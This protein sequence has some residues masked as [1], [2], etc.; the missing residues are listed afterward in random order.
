M[1]KTVHLAV[2]DTFSDWE[3]GFATAHINRELWHREPGA[4]RVRT[5]GATTD[6]VV[7]MGG[8]RVTPDISL[9][10]LTPAD[11]AMLILP[12][13]AT[14]ETGALAAFADKSSE[15]LTAATPVAAIC[16]ATFGLASAGLLDGRPHTSNAAEYLAMSGYS[17]GDKFV[18]ES[19][20]TDGDLITASGTMPVD[21]ARAIL[22]RL[23]IYEP[24]I[25][26]AWYRLYGRNDPAGFFALAEYE[27]SRAAAGAS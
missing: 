14:W 3:T 1:I 12:G 9:E 23:E 6:P 20:V 11:S 13:S 22:G 8:M 25:L 19:A 4:W 18:H 2:Y 7:S 17:G 16:G 27:Q 21:F 5:V 10:D 24:H 15:F 26:D